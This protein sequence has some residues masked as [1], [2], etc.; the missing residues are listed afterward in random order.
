MKFEPVASSH[1]ALPVRGHTFEDLV[2]ITPEVM[3]Y[4]YHRAV[5]KTY[6]GA[7]PEGIKFEKEYELEEYA[8]LQFHKPVVGYGVWKITLHMPTDAAEVIALEITVSPEIEEEKDGHYFAIRER[9]LPVAVFPTIG[10]GKGIFLHF[11]L[12]VLIKLVYNA[13]NY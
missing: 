8:L 3:A 10:G 2:G 12:E 6:A 5:H 1:R 13:E 9:C 7:S 11:L 4:G